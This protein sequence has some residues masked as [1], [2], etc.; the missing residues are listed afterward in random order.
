M[1]LCVLCG[2]ENKQ[3]LFHCTALT[4]WLVFITET[5][6]VYCAVRVDSLYKADYVYSSEGQAVRTAAVLQHT[7]YTRNTSTYPVEPS[8]TSSKPLEPLQLRGS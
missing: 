2:S 1:Y 4:D 7:L 3:R 6:C 5:Q 8:L